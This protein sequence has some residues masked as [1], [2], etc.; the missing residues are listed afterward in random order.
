[1][2]LEDFERSVAAAA[3]DTGRRVRVLRVSSQP[4]DHPVPAA[5]PEGRYLKALLLEVSR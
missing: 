2:S 5:F 1:M 4:A 3:K